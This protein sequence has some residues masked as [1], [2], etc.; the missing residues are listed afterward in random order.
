MN[1]MIGGKIDFA[2]TT[3]VQSSSVGVY[4]HWGCLKFFIVDLCL[5]QQSSV[6]A[7]LGR[8]LMEGSEPPFVRHKSTCSIGSQLGNFFQGNLGEI[9]HGADYPFVFPHDLP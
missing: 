7:Q 9:N 2:R 8:R 1:M 6:V 4:T 5:L 3:I